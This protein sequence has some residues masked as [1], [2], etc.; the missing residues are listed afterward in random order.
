M[1]LDDRLVGINSTA[2]SRDQWARDTWPQVEL[3]WI[4]LILLHFAAL[5]HID[6]VVIHVLS[7]VLKLMPNA[8]AP[9]VDFS[10]ESHC[11]LI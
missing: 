8:V 7:V 2:T 1:F 3:I 4:F 6:P 10:E 11:S 5:I 9:S